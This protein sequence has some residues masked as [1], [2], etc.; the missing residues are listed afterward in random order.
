MG[1]SSRRQSAIRV[2]SDQETT[3]IREAVVLQRKTPNLLALLESHVEGT[4]PE[5]AVNPCPPTPLPPWVSP[6]EP[7]E[8]KR[9]R[10][11]KAGNET[12]KEGEVQ[13]S[14]DQEPPKGS[15]V[16]KGQQRRSFVEGSGLEVTPDCC[17]KVPTWNLPLELNGAPLSVDSSIRD[18]QQGK[19][20]YVANSLD[21][22]LLL[23]QDMADLR[24]LKKY[25]VFLTLKR[26]LAMVGVQRLVPF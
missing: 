11:K 15:K 2:N 9:K 19:T 4:T 26:D 5:V 12:S 10:D 21:Q 25:E 18:F 3:D 7:L 24:G 8:K 23:P 14:K 13:P 22:A 16:A 17:P 20:S 6:A 1:A